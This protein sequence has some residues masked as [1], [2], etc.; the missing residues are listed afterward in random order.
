MEA[1]LSESQAVQ[2]GSHY[3]QPVRIAV[4][5]SIAMDHLMRF[6]GQFSESLLTERLDR[7]SLS[8]LVEDL[9]I[10]R[11]GIGRTRGRI[12]STRA[13]SG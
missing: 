9:Q 7:V 2:C 6:S 11:G 13:Q 12:S 1:G 5:G 4:T 8:F 3:P 10:R